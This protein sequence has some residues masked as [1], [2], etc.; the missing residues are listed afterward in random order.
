M[1]KLMYLK[2]SIKKKSIRMKKTIKL[3]SFLCVLTLL[4]NCVCSFNVSAITKDRISSVSF[5]ESDSR[6]NA[7]PH[8]KNVKL[9]INSSIELYD[10]NE[11]TI[12]LAYKLSPTGYVIMDND[13]NIIE[14]SFTLNLPFSTDKK[15]YYTGPLNYYSKNG[16]FY[17]HQ[18]SQ[19]KVT[20]TDMQL[21]KITKFCAKK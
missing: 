21:N 17:I 8:P 9:N 16:S 7:L 12:A 5:S 18:K 13:S 4:I 3:V 2:K 11:N 14:Y 15:I 1:T 10:T 6:V 20:N 19:E